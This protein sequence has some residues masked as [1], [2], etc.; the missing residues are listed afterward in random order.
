ME[1]TNSKIKNNKESLEIEIII[2]S[3]VLTLFYHF[4]IIFVHQK[5][6]SLECVNQQQPLRNLYSDGFVFDFYVYVSENDKNPNFDQTNELI[7][8]EKNLIYNTQQLNDLILEYDTEISISQV[9]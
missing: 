5:T 1:K 7:W 2:I 4:V 9:S 6:Y 3:I 8:T